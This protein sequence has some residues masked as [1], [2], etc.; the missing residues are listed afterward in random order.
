MLYDPQAE[1]YNDTA[2]TD[3]IWQSIAEVVNDT[4][5]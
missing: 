4:G 3:E 2:L 5:E 1:G